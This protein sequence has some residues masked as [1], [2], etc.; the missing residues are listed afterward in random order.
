MSSFSCVFIQTLLYKVFSLS[1]RALVA[2]GRFVLACFELLTR[3]LG[4]ILDCVSGCLAQIGEFLLFIRIGGNFL[5]DVL[6]DRLPV[7]G[8]PVV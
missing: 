5:D 8:G 2:S 3:A 1:V 7:V 4:P 6:V